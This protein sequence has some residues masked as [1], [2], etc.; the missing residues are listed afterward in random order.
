[1]CCTPEHKWN[2][3]TTSFARP[4]SILTIAVSLWTLKL[5]STCHLPL[6]L[7]R[8]KNKKRRAIIGIGSVYRYEI[9]SLRFRCVDPLLESL[10]RHNFHS[11]AV[12][13]GSTLQMSPL[14]S[15]GFLSYFFFQAVPK[16]EFDLNTRTV[17][18]HL[19]AAFYI[20]SDLLLTTM[21][22]R[23]WLLPDGETHGPCIYRRR[24][25]TR[26]WLDRNQAVAHGEAFGGLNE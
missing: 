12:G 25:H 6:L 26:Y 23:V 21:P 10:P 9:P 14:Y 3:I 16:G 24:R 22:A 17:T 18:C 13:K 7:H 11:K 2:Y 1:M 15:Q 19:L 8:Q 5:Q 20:Y 4:L